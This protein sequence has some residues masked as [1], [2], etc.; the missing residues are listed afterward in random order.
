M[1]V[2]AGEIGAGEVGTGQ[3]DLGI[4]HAG[5]VLAGQVRAG[6]VG[7]GPRQVPVDDA[8]LQGELGR[9]RRDAAGD[10]ARHG[11][12]GEVGVREVS[13]GEG[14]V[15]EVGTGQVDACQVL[16]GQID[17]GQ[18]DPRPRQVP[19]DDAEPEGELWPARS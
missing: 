2:G 11:G 14:V 12:T 1:K 10:H 18:V 19:V 8:E 13:A 3:I 5:Q 15:G 6:E 7:A 16:P 9:H 4:V 17:A